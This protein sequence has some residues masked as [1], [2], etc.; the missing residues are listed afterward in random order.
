MYAG[1]NKGFSLLELLL[2]ATIL[3]IVAI[4]AIP[5]LFSADPQK[6]EVAVQEA[7]MALRY[8]RNEARRTGL[9]HGVRFSSTNHT[10]SVFKLDLS[11]PPIDS[12][13]EI[14]IYH[15]HD[16]KT[17][18]IDINTNNESSGLLISQANFRF[19][20]NTSSFAYVVFNND[21]L[22]LR[23]LSNGTTTE[24]MDSGEVRLSQDGSEKILQ[25]SSMTGRVKIL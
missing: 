22:P 20:G 17:Y 19:G 21:G 5:N 1:V 9:P 2:V 13:D 11:T 14:P 25:V 6:L 15:P 24:I 10:I 23:Y 18:S 7:V 16:K 12:T 3:G 8:A 4:V